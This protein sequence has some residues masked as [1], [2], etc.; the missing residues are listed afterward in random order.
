MASF[1]D[2]KKTIIGL[3][4][5]FSSSGSSHSATVTTVLNAKDL[6]D[7]ESELGSLIGFGAGRTTFSNSQI[8]KLLQN[9][10]EVERTTSQ[11]GN[12]KKVSIKY[13]DSTS[14]KLKSHCFVVRGET[15]TPTI[16]GFLVAL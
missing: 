2:E 1:D 16:E 8:D 15:P 13:E 9:F 12:Q 4:I 5:N 11:D 7:D 6:T 3:E 14:L 10:I